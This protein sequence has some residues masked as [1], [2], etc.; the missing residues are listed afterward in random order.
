MAAG[1]GRR[2]GGR[3]TCWT[4]CSGLCWTG[5]PSWGSRESP[6]PCPYQAQE[7]LSGVAWRPTDKQIRL[8]APAREISGVSLIKWG[9]CLRWGW[10]GPGEEGVPY[11]T[12]WLGGGGA[13]SLEGQGV[14]GSREPTAWCSGLWSP[15]GL[16]FLARPHR[17]STRASP[18]LL[19]QGHRQRDREGDAGVCGGPA[20]S[21]HPVGR[22]L[23]HQ[24]GS[25][26]SG[27]GGTWGD[28]EHPHAVW[29]DAQE[30]TST[31]K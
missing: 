29:M 26:C 21:G 7:L 18:E 30:G 13:R 14:E 11:P 20:C 25:V 31:S 22:G 23:G 9:C 27:I 24:R 28:R 3:G 8:C 2:E 6:F 16:P 19:C 17:T 5:Y 10:T 12:P 15:S 4:L 1:V